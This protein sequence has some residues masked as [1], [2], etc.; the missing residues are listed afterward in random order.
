MHGGGSFGPIVGCHEEAGEKLRAFLEEKEGSA[1]RS[2]IR[3]FDPDMDLRVTNYE[4]GKALQAMGYQGDAKKTFQALDDDGSGEVTLVEIDIDQAH[5]W[6]RFR[7]WCAETFE[8]SEDMLHRIGGKQAKRTGH[9]TQ[10]QFKEGLNNLGW[11]GGEEDLLFTTFEESRQNVIEV[12]NFAWLDVERRR[13]QR[14][15][16]F[17]LKSMRTSIKHAN[18]VVHAKDAL[19]KFKEYLK[20][21]HGTYVKAWRVALSPGDAMVLQKTQFFKACSLL[22]FG[23]DAKLIWHAF[24]KSDSGSLSLDELDPK[25]AEILAQ[26]QAFAQKQFGGSSACFKAFD[27]QNLKKLG[28]PEFVA[29]LK[30]HGCSFQKYAKHLFHYLNREGGKEIREEDMR[31][32]DKWKPPEFLLVPPNRQAMEMVKSMLLDEF[33]HYLK[34]WRRLLDLDSSNRCTWSEFKEA[35][36]KI[37]FSQDAAGAW[38]ALDE[39][40]SGSITLKEIDSTSSE[41]LADF[42][43]WADGEFGSVKT[44][45]YVFDHDNSHSVSSREFRRCCSI[46]GYEGNAHLLFRVLDVEGNGSL[47]ISEISFLD[48]WALTADPEEAEEEPLPWKT[49]RAAG[50]VQGTPRS[51]PSATPGGSAVAG[52]TPRVD[53]GSVQD[54]ER[55]STVPDRPPVLPIATRSGSIGPTRFDDDPPAATREAMVERRTSFEEAEVMRPHT[56]PVVVRTGTGT[57]GGTGSRPMSQRSPRVVPMPERFYWSDKPLSGLPPAPGRREVSSRGGRRTKRWGQAATWCSL[58]R[59]RGPCRHMSP[60]RNISSAPAG[61]VGGG[62]CSGWRPG[63]S[64]VFPPA[65]AAVS[66]DNA[67]LAGLRRQLHKNKPL[68]PDHP[69]RGLPDI[70]A[71]RRLADHVDD[72]GVQVEALSRFPIGSFSAR[73]PEVCSAR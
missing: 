1:L 58:C 73:A 61:G 14:R 40:L 32:L 10:S 35:C 48:E 20:R 17:K 22:G 51:V 36:K 53:S 11:D 19:K 66:A 16:Q 21:I 25:G 34:A 41:S 52:S 44:S 69:R 28:Q 24:G 31:F 65:P 47:G 38:R 6:R 55:P 37:G 8:N 43:R 13:Q 59:S 68:L 12:K 42:K 62:G 72:L 49:P 3:Y 46:Y 70:P 29:A 67:G 18:D 23:A 54:N 64:S 56:S 63:Y 5:L 57:T 7:L 39:D 9:L 26:L 30:E 2:W 33:G 71:T 15:L 4:F 45:Y 50:S 60:P 27:K